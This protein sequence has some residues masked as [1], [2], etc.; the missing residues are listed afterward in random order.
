MRRH[1]RF[2]QISR[3]REGS[4]DLKTAKLPELCLMAV[5]CIFV[6]QE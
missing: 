2:Q 5:F 1:D 3:W 4:A 6:L